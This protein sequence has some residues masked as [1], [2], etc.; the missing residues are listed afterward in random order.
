MPRAS[1]RFSVLP[2]CWISVATKTSP[3]FPQ[4]QPVLLQKSRGRQADKI[5]P[6]AARQAKLDAGC[7]GRRSGQV[8]HFGYLAFDGSQVG[9]TAKPFGSPELHSPLRRRGSLM[10]AAGTV[11]AAVAV[12]VVIRVVIAIVRLYGH[13][14]K[15][16]IQEAKAQNA[17]KFHVFHLY[18]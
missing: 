16:E 8:N 7:F 6:G 1:R 14:A 13:G 17:E 9:D 11:A 12:T 10:I 5:T 18:L 2:L 15:P 4:C 3:S